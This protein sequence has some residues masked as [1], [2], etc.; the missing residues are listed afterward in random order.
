MTTAPTIAEPGIYDGIGNAEYHAHHALSSSGM[1]LLIEAPAL[2]DH[3]R[4]NPRQSQ[5]F[6]LGSVWHSLVLG[7]DTVEY[8]V[9]QKTNRQKE[10]V[11]AGDY[12]TV[13]AAEHRDQIIADGKT[14]ILRRDLL[15]AEAMAEVFN[16]HPA[17]TE[18]LRDVP[19]AIERSAFW[20]DQRTGVDLRVR[21]DFLPEARPG[22][23]FTIVDPKTARSAEPQSWLRSA[24]DYGYAIQAALYIR[25]AKEFGLHPRPDFLFLVQDKRAPYIVTPIRLAPRSLAIGDH[26]VDRA[27]DRFVA[28]T[29]S[30]HW[31]GY[32]DDVVVDDL[33]KFFTDRFED[34]A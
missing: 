32:S 19:G 3:E 12:D 18:Y 29:E 4:K 8:V 5:A 11:D 24:V 17:V 10:R 27:I 9:V 25:A 28:C 16:R 22:K 7:D 30:G 23:S 13:S 31:P 6:D 14:P 34:V 15:L 20:T 21:F 26:L 1:K 33:P 2:F